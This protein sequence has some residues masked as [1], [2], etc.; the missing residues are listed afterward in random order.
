MESADVLQDAIR[1]AWRGLDDATI[2]GVLPHLREHVLAPGE[3]LFRQGD[4]VDCLYLVT[5]GRLSI[6][7]EETGTMVLEE[8]GPRGIVGEIA[9]LVGGK[10]TATARAAESTRVV[11][12]PRERLESLFRDH[13]ALLDA[14]AA[15]AHHRLRRNMIAKH[16]GALFGAIDREALRE[17]EERITWVQLRSGDELFH[18]GAPA[19]GAYIVALGRLRVAVTDPA[20]GERMIDE[21]GPGEWVGEM[22]L[23]TRK[24]R[25][26]T[27]YAVRDTELLWLSQQVFD[28]LMVRHPVALLETSRALV[29]R[30]QRRMAATST[31][32]PRSCCRRSSWRPAGCSAGSGWV[33]CGSAPAFSTR[34][35][36]PGAWR[37]TSIRPIAAAPA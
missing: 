8:I 37:S 18:Q 26:A 23:L 12:L 34:R 13:P 30:L 20:G 19:D 21:L 17:L 4:D 32:R 35:Q 2:K 14:V 9:V 3:V 11:G 10:R 33:R 27:V 31:L 1:S 5:H 29:L 36:K 7:L 28:E 16:V 24:P 25:S 15:A 22:A 6:C